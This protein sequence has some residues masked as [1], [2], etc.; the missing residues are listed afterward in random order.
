MTKVHARAEIRAGNS[1]NSRKKVQENETDGMPPIPFAVIPAADRNEPE[2]TLVRQRMSDVPDSYEA[3]DDLI[4]GVLCP[5]DA[6]MIFAPPG[7]QKSYFLFQLALALATGEHPFP[8]A[9]N[10]QNT[11]AGERTRVLFVTSEMALRELQRRHGV[12]WKQRVVDSELK[13]HDGAPLE[14]LIV[15]PV[16]RMLTPGAE[17]SSP[18]DNI[19]AQLD[20]A[21][22]DGYPAQA[23]IIDNVTTLWPAMLSDNKDAAELAE[24]LKTLC[25]EDG[26]YFTALAYAMHLNKLP[27]NMKYENVAASAMKGNAFFEIVTQRAIGFN[28]STTRTNG[29]YM[30]ELKNRW[31]GKDETY[32]KKRVAT[33]VVKPERPEL[34]KKSPTWQHF[35]GISTEDAERGRE[36]APTEIQERWTRDYLTKHPAATYKE[37]HAAFMSTFPKNEAPGQ[38]KFRDVRDLCRRAAGHDELKFSIE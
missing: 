31:T 7:C 28:E 27:A 16:N 22:L 8:G 33:F 11:R 14:W 10:L 5:G 32:H 4:S 3:P 20:A 15:L 21:K 13:E 2:P 26:E 25:S 12:S 18:L 24:D 19:R 35:D 17:R 30:V 34:G 6:T 36:A 1:T 29:V 23:V 38:T 9:T 37:F